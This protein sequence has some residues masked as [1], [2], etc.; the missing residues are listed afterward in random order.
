MKKNNNAFASDEFI[1]RLSLK[2]SLA[3]WRLTTV[4]LFI[5]LVVM[6]KFFDF[7]KD[8]EIFK[9]NNEYIVKLKLEG[10]I[11][12]NI[13]YL[14][15]IE[16]IANDSKA[17]AIILE[18]DSPGGAITP[19]E[20]IYSALSDLSAKK[21]VVSY[22]DSFGAS[23]GYMAAIASDYIIARSTTQTGSI[24]VF[25]TSYDLTLLF[26]KLG[27]KTQIFRAGD[28]KSPPFEKLTPEAIQNMNS[29]IKSLHEYFISLV[30]KE[31][32][33][34]IE[35]VRDIANGSVYNGMEA[36]KLGLID[37]IGGEKEALE[38]LY[39]NK[40]SRSLP[41]KSINFHQYNRE[42]SN[43]FKKIFNKLSMDF[44]IKLFI[45]LKNNYINQ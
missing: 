13:D 10:E 5:A 11:S 35:R 36:L 4:I 38:W 32:S 21:H 42:T 24:G 44:M 39:N 29:N 41:I 12:S 43:F 45:D 1:D 8:Y 6:L 16:S 18:I 33:L 3:Y 23:G 28:A 7:H 17:K 31:R 37:Q 14:S 34:N 26:D 25:T 9:K 20:I 15:V 2:S 19:S 22:M 27:I 40:I 30:S